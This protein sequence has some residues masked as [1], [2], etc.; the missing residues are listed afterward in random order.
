MKLS[1]T[2]MGIGVALSAAPTALSV[3]GPANSSA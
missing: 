3:T 2:K 1:G